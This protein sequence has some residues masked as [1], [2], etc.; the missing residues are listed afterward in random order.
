MVFK[1]TKL[2][3]ILVIKKRGVFVGDRNNMFINYF[4][5]V[6]LTIN[7]H[8]TAFYLR[9]QMFCM[10]IS[11]KSIDVSFQST[12]LFVS[13]IWKRPTIFTWRGGAW[14]LLLDINPYFTK[15]VFTPLLIVLVVT[16]CLV[17][18]FVGSDKLIGCSYIFHKS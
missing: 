6:C 13:P 3:K 4:H 17:L 16:K 8:W 9:H 15:Y 5:W 1:V 18:F 14:R 11:H 7:Y 10:S 2:I 12:A